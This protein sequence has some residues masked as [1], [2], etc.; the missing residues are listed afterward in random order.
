MCEKLTDCG[1]L[2][3]GLKNIVLRDCKCL[4]R[5][6]LV[7]FQPDVVTVL[8]TNVEQAKER[9]DFNLFP[10]TAGNCDVWPGHAMKFL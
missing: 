10:G 4:Q 5:V 3:S 7:I 8:R 2:T 6:G 1:I 9:E